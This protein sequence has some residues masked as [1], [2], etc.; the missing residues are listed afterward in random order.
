MALESSDILPGIYAAF[1]T[2]VLFVILSALFVGAETA[3]GGSVAAGA[4]GSGAFG[5]YTV[6][7]GLAAP[8][9]GALQ[10]ARP[11]LWF[12]VWAAVGLYD[13]RYQ[14]MLASAALALGMATCYLMG[15]AVAAWRR[16]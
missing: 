16:R 7:R 11:W 10:F 3:A 6:A 2:V 1:A 4:V 8:L 14:P 13:G 9:R 15:G 12:T 5:F